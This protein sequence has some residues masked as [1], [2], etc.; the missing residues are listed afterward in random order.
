MKTV[1][2][3]VIGSPAGNGGGI[4]DAPSDGIQYARQNGEWVEVEGGGSC[5]DTNIKN[6]LTTVENQLTG[7]EELLA[8]I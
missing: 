5:D 8:S 7:L 4:P 2:M 6:I 3:T 1:N